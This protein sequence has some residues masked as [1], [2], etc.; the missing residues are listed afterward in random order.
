M[1]Y[2]Q[3]PIVRHSNEYG[4]YLIISQTNESEYDDDILC[5]CQWDF[6]FFNNECSVIPSIKLKQL[7]IRCPKRLHGFEWKLYYSTERDGISMN[8]MYDKLK[9]VESSIL[10]IK[11]AQNQNIF[12]AFIDCEWIKPSLQRKCHYYGSIDC[13]VFDSDFKIYR[14]SNESPY[15]VQNDDNGITIGAGSS[16]AIYFDA[17]F[18]FGR[19]VPCATYNNPS[20]LSLECDFKINLIEIWAPNTN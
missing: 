3:N 1:E 17:D 13:F 2:T 14:G 8:T 9:G 16:P 15:Y 18:K 4:K 12:G 10:I 6:D 7:I 20:S 11:E 19:S 5:S